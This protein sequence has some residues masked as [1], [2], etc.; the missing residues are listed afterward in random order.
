[1]HPNR[2]WACVLAVP[3]LTAGCTLTGAA[4]SGS[5]SGHP[6]R[7]KAESEHT[8]AAKVSIAGEQRHGSDT[9]VVPAADVERDDPRRADD[10][11][12]V[13]LPAWGGVSVD[14]SE[15]GDAGERD[16]IHEAA[17]DAARPLAP[18]TPWWRRAKDAGSAWVPP[19]FVRPSA[20]P[21]PSA[22]PVPS[23]TPWP[24]ATVPPTPT[25]D[26]IA[27][28]G[29]P[30]RLEIPAIGVDAVIEH[31]GLTAERAMD[32]PQDWMNVAWYEGGP[33]PGATGNSVIAGHFDTSTGGPAVFW[34][35]NRLSPGDEA[36]I[37]Y[38]GGDRYT[39]IV[40]ELAEYDYDAKDDVIDTIFGE[41]LAPNLN[42]ITCQGVWDYG[43]GTY[44]KRLVVFTELVP[45][46]TVYAASGT[47][48]D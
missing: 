7:V 1:M 27:A 20:T 21:E 36:I 22:T 31:V 35:L 38:E 8:V 5:R 16:R 2:W 10:E 9:A 44:N 26:V 18:E 6:N 13:E 29:V 43:N 19:A 40:Q 39:F 47:V 46:L 3:L 17:G 37:T 30:V 45:E 33:M 12:F 25:E 48:R 42:L 41:S 4:G 28:A 34:M 15:P 23:I 32:V 24:S 14:A 11:A